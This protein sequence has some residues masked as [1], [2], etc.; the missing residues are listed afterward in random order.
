MI[1][2]STFNDAQEAKDFVRHLQLKEGPLAD[3]SPDD[4]QVYAISKQNYTTLYNRKR[5][6]A[7]K[8]FYDKYY[9]P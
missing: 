1:T 4:Y 8:E 5:V 6:A 7:Y 9:T 3:Y 2:I